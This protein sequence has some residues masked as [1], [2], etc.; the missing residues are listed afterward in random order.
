MRYLVLN[1]VRQDANWVTYRR[2]VQKA[3]ADAF[4]V[5]NGITYIEASAKTS[6]GVDEAFLSTANK[7]WEKMSGGV[8]KRNNTTTGVS[9][10]H[11]KTSSYMI[12]I[13][14]YIF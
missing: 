14:V 2:Q 1:L 11:F 3:E 13:K 9:Y 6:D 4:A 7:I 5:E 12:A 10:H 8:L